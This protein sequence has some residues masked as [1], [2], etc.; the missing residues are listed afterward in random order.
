MEYN[1]PW[2]NVKSGEMWNHPDS[3]HPAVCLFLRTRFAPA[4]GLAT[5]EL[6]KISLDRESFAKGPKLLWWNFCS[7]RR[8]GQKHTGLRWLRDYI[9]SCEFHYHSLAIKNP[10]CTPSVRL[11]KTC[12]LQLKF[13]AVY[14]IN[15][16]SCQRIVFT[17]PRMA[18]GIFHCSAIRHEQKVQQGQGAQNHF[19]ST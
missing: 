3:G 17:S 7:D 1:N 11:A 19:H 6:S 12:Q 2:S 18:R 10:N 4:F 9:P 16:G 15:W 14:W 8:A 13:S 5:T